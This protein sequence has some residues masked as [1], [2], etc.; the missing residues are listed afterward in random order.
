MHRVSLTESGTA[1]AKVREVIDVDNIEMYPEGLNEAGLEGTWT[2]AD[3]ILMLLDS[4]TVVLSITSEYKDQRE[5][6]LS[7]MAN[8]HPRALIA[9]GFRAL[10]KKGLVDCVYNVETAIMESA[11]VFEALGHPVRLHILQHCLYHPSTA[12]ELRRLTG[13]EV[14]SIYH[15]TSKLQDRNLLYSLGH[16][17]GYV[18]DGE[19]LASILRAL[20]EFFY[21]GRS[22]DGK[23]DVR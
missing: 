9:E 10:C 14:P 17:E 6:I 5:A 12:S 15:H 23:N 11:E 19:M 13:R 7:A 22:E 21:P 8:F 1:L 16:G 2:V 3:D 18:T 20:I 4:P